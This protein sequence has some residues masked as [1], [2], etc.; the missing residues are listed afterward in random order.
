MTTSNPADKP[1]PGNVVKSLAEAPESPRALG[2]PNLVPVWAYRDDGIKY[3]IQMTAEDAERDG[4][5][6]VYPP[7]PEPEPKAKTEPKPKAKTEPKPKAKKPKD[8][9]RTKD[10]ARDKAK[11]AGGDKTPKA[12]SEVVTL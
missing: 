12:G 4:F 11:T 1:L 9:S 5:E 3:A 10:T 7:E 6:L 2:G 8:K